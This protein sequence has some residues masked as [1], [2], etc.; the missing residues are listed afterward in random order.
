MEFQNDRS[1]R[2]ALTFDGAVSF[3]SPYFLANE[4]DANFKR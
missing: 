1:L 2:E 3:L 4:I